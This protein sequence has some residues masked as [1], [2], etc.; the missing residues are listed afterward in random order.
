MPQALK[1]YLRNWIFLGLYKT[2]TEELRKWLRYLKMI[3]NY[4]SH[5]LNPLLGQNMNLLSSHLMNGDVT[6]YEKL[7]N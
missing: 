1:L 4:Q 7:T 6:N 2:N 5:F 3:S